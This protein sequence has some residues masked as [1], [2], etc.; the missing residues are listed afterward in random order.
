MKRALSPVPD[1]ALTGGLLASLL[2]HSVLLVGLAF[3]ERGTEPR[4]GPVLHMV[5][6]RPDPA[7]AGE[8]P[9][10]E[11]PAASASQEAEGR[12]PED[13]EATATR[14]RRSP[15]P[16]RASQPPPPAESDRGPQPAER[17]SGAEAADSGPDP[18]LTAEQSPERAPSSPSANGTEAPAEGSRPQASAEPF[19][20][21]PSD[22]QVARW[23][24]RQRRRHVAKTEDSGQA[25]RAATRADQAAAYIS[26]WLS[27]VERIGNLNYPEEARE[28]GITGQV[29]VEARIRPD[30][31][32]DR[33]RVL[34]SSGHKVLD[35]AAKRII[36]MG[37]PY[38]PFSE[39][40]RRR[41]AQGLP[42][43]HHFTFTRSASLETP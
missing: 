28:R 42:I 7:G 39:K 12:S 16:A 40:L 15:S 19:R 10:T 36:R 33:I 11:A 23:D 25:P 35:K 34:E 21:F 26:A 41:Y 8:E 5:E 38:S 17:S 13:Q 1:P 32:L 24:R 4:A 31:A 2:V 6:Y 29:R 3:F 20:L 37:A 30:G 22:R 27:K 14:T 43:R 18:A 9:D